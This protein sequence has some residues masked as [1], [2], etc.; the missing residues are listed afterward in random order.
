ML[1]RTPFDVS[2]LENS[3]GDFRGRQVLCFDNAVREHRG[4]T[5]KKSQI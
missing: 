1:F 3:T 4:V 5:S 2:F